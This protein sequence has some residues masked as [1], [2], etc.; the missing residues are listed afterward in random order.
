[1]F[2]DNNNNINLVS[3]LF[4][5]FQAA[6]ICH[7]LICH[8]PP[9][10]VQSGM[11]APFFLDSYTYPTSQETCRL[12]L[13]SLQCKGSVIGDAKVAQTFTID[14]DAYLDVMNYEDLSWR[15]CLALSSFAAEAS[16]Y[17]VNIYLDF[18]AATQFRP[19]F[20]Y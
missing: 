6:M 13:K 19:I 3:N 12:E 7:I 10:S 1:M 11:F 18:H 2:L 20:I 8:Y 17:T 5:H 15:N 14:F 9:I 16:L 4:Y